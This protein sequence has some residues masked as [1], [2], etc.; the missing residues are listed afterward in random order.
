MNINPQEIAMNLL[1][2]KMNS[3]P[4]VKNLFDL[5][6]NGDFSNI[7]QI[8]RNLCASR[9]INADEAYQNIVNQLMPSKKV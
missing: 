9:G 5:A 8:A 6:S 3:N 1:K 4:M 2:Q 7:E